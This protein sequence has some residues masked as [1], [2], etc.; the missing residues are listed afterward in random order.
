MLAVQK[1]AEEGRILTPHSNSV[2]DI[3]GCLPG[4]EDDGAD[5]AKEQKDA[6][7]AKHVFWNISGNFIYRHHVMNRE[8]HMCFEQNHFLFQ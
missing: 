1:V 4:E 7:E 8:N 3:S 5:A 6:M 2:E